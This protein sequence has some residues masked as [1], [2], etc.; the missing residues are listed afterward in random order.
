[1][2]PPFDDVLPR[3]YPTQASGIDRP[4]YPSLIR[5][6][7]VTRW[8]L[9]RE[10]NETPQGHMRTDQQHPEWKYKRDPLPVRDYDQQHRGAKV[11][12][13]YHP[14]R[15]NGAAQPD[16]SG[17]DHSLLPWRN[18]DRF[19]VRPHIDR[20]IP[21]KHL[22]VRNDQARFL[23]DHAS[24]MVGQSAVRVRDVRTAFDH[25]DIGLL[26]ESAQT[27]RTRR[28]VSNSTNY[29]DF[30]DGPF[31]FSILGTVTRGRLRR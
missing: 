19:A 17:R 6:R 27:R 7:D 26:I 1:M 30:Q 12:N 22:L 18:S 20:K 4:V 23:R 14:T 21:A 31:P 29:G 25:E 15:E 5:Q 2:M 13:K 24:Y 28:A 10:G 3:L 8:Q 11:A 9:L 16:I